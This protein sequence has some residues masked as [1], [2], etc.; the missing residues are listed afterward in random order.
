M[1]IRCL[2]T[3]IQVAESGSFTRAAEILG[4]SQPTISVQI[5]Q[6]EKELGVQLFDRIGHTVTLTDGGRDALMYAQ[7]I[8]RISQEMIQGSQDKLDA[9]GVIRIAMPDSLCIPMISER[10]ASFREAYPNLYLDVITT[11]THE[12]YHMLDHN[13]ADIVCTLDTH[14]NDVSYIIAAE[15]RVEAHF[16][17][18]P[19]HPLAQYQQISLE[20]LLE[21]P[22]LLTEKGMSYRRLMDE[23]FAQQGLELQPILEMGN[24]GIICDL[25]VDGAGLSF[26]PDFVT[27]RAVREG[28]IVRLNVPECHIE[29]WK[30]LL[31][32][33]DKW[34][35]LSMQAVIGHLSKININ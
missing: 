9:K 11:D 25:V 10:F 14:L 5:K 13:E 22:F 34:L 26:L 32:H 4:Y 2:T 23:I 16:V 19:G 15:E 20:Q 29:L 7:K 31:Y 35:S 21:Y 27:E 30:Q 8:C 6:L 24:T 17:C 18:Q 12:M 28:K 1:D 3:F 33:R